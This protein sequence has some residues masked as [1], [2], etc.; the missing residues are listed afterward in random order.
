VRRRERSGKVVRNAVDKVVWV[1]KGAAF[2][3]GLAVIFAAV[4]AVANAVL[5]DGGGPSLYGGS[6]RA[7]P[8]SQLAANGGV[9]LAA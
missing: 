2:L 3:V 1:G 8:T 7:D 6:Y 4:F 5:G 9:G